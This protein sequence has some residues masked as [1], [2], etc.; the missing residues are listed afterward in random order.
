MKAIRKPHSPV[1]SE[2]AHLSP[3]QLEYIDDR[4]LT[5]PYADVQ[6]LIFAEFGIEISINKLFRYYH[7][8]ALA[9]LLEIP[10]T[11]AEGA[12]QLQ[13]LYNGEPVQLDE[14]GLEAIQRRALELAISPSTSPSLLLNLMRVFT[15]EH[16]KSMDEHRKKI[17]AEKS[18]HRKRLAEI[19]ERHAVVAERRAGCEEQ[20]VELLRLHQ[21]HL[22]KTKPGAAAWPQDEINRLIDPEL[23][24]PHPGH[25]A[26]MGSARRLAGV[27]PASTG[28]PPA[29]P[30]SRSKHH[31]NPLPPNETTPNVTDSRG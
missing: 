17:D 27:S 14:A 16:R 7:K 1:P 12:S 22:E 9:R 10:G 18:A 19:A 21:A 30:S 26:A 24:Y 29:A 3:K 5:Q 11:P 28:V 4:L 25:A 2:F 8:L 20:R 15:W 6:A 13:K 31:V 23:R